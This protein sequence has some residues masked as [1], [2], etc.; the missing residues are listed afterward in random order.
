MLSA[1]LRHGADR[2]RGGVLA[3]PVPFA[4]MSGVRA[5]RAGHP[6][7]DAGSLAA[8]R[9]AL[10][11]AAGLGEHD[12]LLVL[13]SGG[14]SALLAAPADTITL[15]D[16]LAVTSLL[17]AAG[18]S[19]AE[20]NTVRKH[21]SAIKGGRL[22]AATRARVT[23]LAVSDVV[24]PIDNDPSV[25]GSGPTVADPTS[26]SAAIDV[27][28][29]TGVGP[30]VPTAVRSHLAAGA[31]GELAETPKPGD[32]RLA[33]STWRLAGGRHDA[34]RGAAG[35][36]G[37][38]GY[39]VAVIDEPVT[40]E[41][42]LAG[43]ALVARAFDTCASLRRPACVVS[44]GETV[45]RV[46]GTGTGGRN[47][48]LA[49]AAARALASAGEP[50]AL[51]SVGTDGID[52]PTDAAGAIVDRETLSRARAA[53]LEDPERWLAGNDAYHFFARLGDL[54]TTGPTRTNVADLQVVLIG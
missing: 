33:R 22:A 5:F 48:E 26:Y 49:L 1:V 19:I 47:Q 44:S 38:R 12:D 16:K 21:L 2:C 43:P 15:D 31:R 32:P 11:V 50:A 40:G 45:V 39:H 46:A 13:L 7:P 36:A 30:R 37:R 54:V 17:L 29:R 23:T 6:I 14:A 42:R 25:I 34:M 24:A 4:P 52:G 53:G 35:L 8:A 27:L 9:A 28:R 41:A 20:L 10:A 18:A 3:A 51:A